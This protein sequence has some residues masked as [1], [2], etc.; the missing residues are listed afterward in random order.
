MRVVV[1]GVQVDPGGVGS[2]AGVRPVGEEH[3]LAVTGR[4]Q[5]SVASARLAASRSAR[6][7]ARTTNSGGTWGTV[8]FACGTNDI[9]LNPQ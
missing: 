3:R 9:A 1:V 6:S 8:I 4:A 5:T 2:G 7:P